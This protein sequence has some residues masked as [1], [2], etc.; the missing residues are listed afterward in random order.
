M[1]SYLAKRGVNIKIINKDDTELELL[2][3]WGGTW[4]V[5]P[6]GNIQPNQTAT[7]TFDGVYVGRAGGIWYRAIDATSKDEIG[8]VNM[9]FGLNSPGYFSAEGTHTVRNRFFSSGLQNYSEPSDPPNTITYKIGEDNQAHWYSGS[10][11]SDSIKC[12]ETTFYSG[13]V[14]VKMHNATKLDLT[15]VRYWSDNG[16]GA[17]NWYWEPSSKDVPD[18]GNTRTVILKNDFRAG[19]TFSVDGV[20]GIKFTNL[21]FIS[22]NLA[23]NSAEGCGDGGRFISPGLQKYEKHGT[24][25]YLQYELGTPNVDNWGLQTWIY[26]ETICLQTKFNNNDQSSPYDRVFVMIGRAGAGKTSLTNL[27]LTKEERFYVNEN[28]CPHSVTTAVQSRHVVL[29]R[30]TVRE[31]KLPED[32][33]IRIKVTDQPGMGDT[34]FTIK[35]HSDNLIK[36]LS[37]LN[38]RTLPTFLIIINLEANRVSEDR[39]LVLTQLSELLI[40]SS[41]SLFSNAIVVFT[42]ADTIDCEDNCEKLMQI[43]PEGWQELPDLL[44]AVNDRYI[45]VNAKDTSAVNRNQILK[46]LFELSKP[47][48]HIRFHGNIDFPST[49][50]KQKLNIPG[51]VLLE[52]PLYKLNLQFHPDL[53]VL[54]FDE[55]R[56][57]NDNL[58]MQIERAIESMLA[59]GEGVSAMVV[60]ISLVDLFSTEMQSLILDLPNCYISEEESASQ[61]D[62][63]WWKYVFIVFKVHDEVTAVKEIKSSLE[64]NPAIKSLANKAG[65]KCTWISQDTPANICRDRL[66][67]TCLNVRKD[68]GG[69]VFIHD[70][71][72]K[73]LKASIVEAKKYEG[74]SKVVLFSPEFHE[75]LAKGA[76]QIFGSKDSIVMKLG[77]LPLEKKISVSTIQLV[78][79]GTRLSKQDIQRFRA[80]YSNPNEKVSIKEV[81]YFL[82]N[83]PPPNP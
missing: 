26:G 61:R 7:Y 52:E 83:E 37:D 19:L 53:N 11:Y 28:T 2:G 14:W 20:D 9:S 55:L 16:K 67:E 59:L 15:F 23:T 73:E 17:I 34:R 58:D 66:I 64:H 32:S 50:L 76:I 33:K 8:F 39:F 51:D 25:L 54:H 1:A 36:C 80:K 30:D 45:F 72:I 46:K 3:E 63:D 40:K 57:R 68:N 18:Q 60:L 81:L 10:S 75:K 6:K 38:V 5:P 65:N 77:I 62:K 13:R 29:P 79:R 71:V 74:D 42:H 31:M 21:S 4:I 49:F 69:K 27:F 48:L 78:L 82:A 43:K 70:T 12:D 22:S 41:Y 24:P 35:E 56:E 44:K 47:T